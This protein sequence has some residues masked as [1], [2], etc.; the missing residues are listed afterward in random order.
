MTQPDPFKPLKVKKPFLL[1]V[2]NLR[3]NFERISIN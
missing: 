2:D 1:K 3:L